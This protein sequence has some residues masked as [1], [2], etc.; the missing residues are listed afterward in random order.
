VPPKR[1]RAFFDEAV[2]NGVWKTADVMEPRGGPGVDAMD[3]SSPTFSP[4]TTGTIT[5][6]TDTVSSSKGPLR[7]GT[8][9]YEVYLA[10]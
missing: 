7:L 3:W 4:A 10:K 6:E 1:S 5:L 9:G 8:A 2:S